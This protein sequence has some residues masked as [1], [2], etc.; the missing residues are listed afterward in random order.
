[1]FAYK[2]GD[3]TATFDEIPA[4]LQA[5]RPLWRGTWTTGWTHFEIFSMGARTYMFAYKAGDGTATF[6][7]LDGD[8]G[9]RDR[10]LAHTNAEVAAAV[11]TALDRA[12]AVAWA[13]RG[14]PVQQAALRAPLGWIAVSGEDD[15]PHR[16]V[17]VPPPPYEQH[18]VVVP[19]EWQG[20]ATRFF[21]ASAVEPPLRTATPRARQT[22][23][24]PPAP[25]VPDDHHVILFLHGHSSGAD[26]AM[27]IIPA[28]LQAG[29]DRGVK[30][31]VLAVDLPN[32]GYSQEFD[33]LAFSPRTESTYPKDPADQTHIN[34][35]V[36]DFIENFV[37]AF[38]DSLPTSISTKLVAV[39]GGS[40]GGNLTLRLGRRDL[41]GKSWKIPAIVSWD[42]AS[43]W[44]PKV[45]HLIEYMA[46]NSCF[47]QCGADELTESRDDFFFESYLK[48]HALGVIQPQPEYWYRDG[49]VGKPFH[50]AQ[51]KFARFEIYSRFFRQWH[52]RVAGEQLIYSHIDN[53]IFRDGST[54]FRYEGNVVRTLLVAGADDDYLGTRIYSNTIYLSEKI[55]VDGRRLL[56]NT[57]G[58]SVH[59]ERPAYF[60][61]EI[62]KFLNGRKWFVSCVK[63]RGGKIE[64]YGIKTSI[65]PTEQPVQ[66]SLNWCIERIEQGDDLYTIGADGSQGYVRVAHRKPFGPMGDPGGENKSYYLRTVGDPTD[67]NNIE[68]IG[69]CM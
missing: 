59:F 9:N 2:A 48:T 8:L 23:D 61:R 19:T 46:P 34:A 49:Y 44:P 10:P 39:I 7:E 35:P 16:P 51:S 22:P 57:T 6:D 14:P 50:I 37:V 29:L 56:L 20:I 36:L 38:V 42:A 64:S 21:I 25:T 26:E 27:G 63:R 67:L 4:D 41:T 17:N 47:D 31:S 18:E 54:P 40:L 58:H 12:Y 68:L 60:A 62:V 30:Y 55:P 28:L 69:E 11:D 3:G 65:D 53:E 24:D 33:H 13:L 66:R 15:K 1:M 43:V 52:W 45:A 32:N 5:T